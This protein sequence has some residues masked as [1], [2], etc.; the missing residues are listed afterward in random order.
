MNNQLSR[1]RTDSMIAGVCAGLA[2][3]LGIDVVLVRLF[4][5]LL[6]LGGGSGMLI[7][8]VL[9]MIMPLEGEGEFGSEATL[10]ASTSEIADHARSV[11]GRAASSAPAN[12]Q[13]TILV[14]MVLVLIGAIVLLRN[15]GMPWMMWLHMGT[16]W[17]LLLIVGGVALLWRRTKEV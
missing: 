11:V 1:S 2:R 8:L 15:L 3:T 17:P 6:V 10:R 5:V 4:F 9:W 12:R 13:T 7:Y 14:G 16:I